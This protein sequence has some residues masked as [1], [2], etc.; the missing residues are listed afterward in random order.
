MTGSI[1]FASAAFDKNGTFIDP[2]T[3]SG[4]YPGGLTSNNVLTISSFS[5]SDSSVIVGSITYTASIEDKEEIETITR[6]EDGEP[7]SALIVTSNQNQFFYK[8]TDLSVEP[9]GQ[10]IQIQVKEKSCI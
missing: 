6:F 10:Q 4:A 3:Y 9:S 5:G 2:S 1:T 7:A 8:A